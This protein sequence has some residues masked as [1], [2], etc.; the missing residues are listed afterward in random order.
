MTDEEMRAYNARKQR[1]WRKQNPERA[2]ANINRWKEKNPEK[3]KEYNMQY[4]ERNRELLKQ[5]AKE[6][7]QMMFR[8]MKKYDELVA[9]GIVPAEDIIE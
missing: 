3:M 5:K 7:Y 6:R 8:K 9:R 2:Y 1:E 4:R